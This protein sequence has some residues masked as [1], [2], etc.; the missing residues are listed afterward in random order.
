MEMWDIYDQ[1][2]IKQDRTMKRGE[3]FAE[4]DY[5]LVVHVCIFN[6]QGEMLIQQRQP[7][8]QG[9]SNYWDVTVGGS[10]VAGDDSSQAASRELLE[11]IGLELDFEHLRPHLTVHFEHG[12]DDIYLVE[13]EVDLAS[14][15]L[16]YEEVQAVKWATKDEIIELI[17][18]K[19]FIPYYESLLHLLFDMRK[20]RGAIDRVIE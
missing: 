4:G 3:S 19:Q 10:A 11:E 5:H 16:Q 2:R 14:L 6:K 8:K 12:F 18:Q 15:S 1:N 13:H 20:G 17:K 7:F 9:W